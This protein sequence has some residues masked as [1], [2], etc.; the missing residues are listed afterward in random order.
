M[1]ILL[2]A[3]TAMVLTSCT[4]GPSVGSIEDFQEISAMQIDGDIAAKDI[5]IHNRRALIFTTYWT[6]ITP[7]DSVY[8]CSRDLSTDQC[9]KQRR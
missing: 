4:T 5:R 6:A 8:E 7:D 2:L 1:R 9:K 3:M